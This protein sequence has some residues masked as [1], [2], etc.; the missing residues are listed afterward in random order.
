MSTIIYQEVTEKILM[1]IG[2][3]MIFLK[4]KKKNQPQNNTLF[5]RAHKIFFTPL[6]YDY[7]YEKIL[8]ILMLSIWTFIIFTFK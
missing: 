2:T 1:S 3:H 5:H 4:K 8:T 6:Q 7:K